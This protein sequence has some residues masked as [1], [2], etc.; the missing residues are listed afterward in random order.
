MKTLCE[1]SGIPLRTYYYNKDNTTKKDKDE[2]I[3][4]S[5]KSMPEE[6]RKAY[7]NKRKAKYLSLEL[8]EK[9][10]H[11]RVQRI[12]KENNLQSDVRISKKPKNNKKS[13]DE[14]KNALPDNILN[15]DFSANKPLEKLLTDISYF[16]VRTG[17]LFLSPVM[18]V[19]NKEIIAFKC[20]HHANE[21]LVV[22]T[23]LSIKEK[24]KLQ[25]AIIQTDQGSTYR[26]KRFRKLLEE[27]GIIHSMSRR[28][29]CWDN[30]CIE[31][32]FGM[33]KSETGYYKTLKNGLLTY[34]QMEK[35]I[36]N[37]IKFF[38]K[39]RIQKNLNWKSPIDFKKNLGF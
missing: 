27:K 37:Y 33:L 14:Y 4:K 31:N 21:E 3:I 34:E 6:E 8:G 10:N 9:I 11:K 18:D 30:A 16:H 12:C 5:I 38:N 7:G 23:I 26:A 29:N 32:F 20:S 22:D 1:V 13:K 35:L 19:F 2:I 15:R 39:R 17:W 25:D 24:E 36:S 28:G